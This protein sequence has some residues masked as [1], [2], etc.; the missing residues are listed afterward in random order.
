MNTWNTDD[1]RVINSQTCEQIF[2]LLRR[3]ATQVAYMRIENVFLNS[4]YF[5]ACWNK[6]INN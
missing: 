4:R 1:M 5:L 3:I 6:G 2:S